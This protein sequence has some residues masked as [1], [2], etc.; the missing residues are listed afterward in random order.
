M[1]GLP[2]ARSRHTTAAAPAAATSLRVRGPGVRGAD[3]V[4]REAVVAA[5]PFQV[6]HHT[7]AE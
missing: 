6:K 4:I 7:P 5:T 2:A 3:G 1:C